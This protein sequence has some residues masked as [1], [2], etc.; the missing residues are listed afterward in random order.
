MKKIS[1]LFILFIFA[2]SSRGMA[3][4][5]SAESLENADYK[6]DL[7]NAL[8]EGDCSFMGVDGFVGNYAIN[9]EED[10][11]YWVYQY[12][13]KHISGTGDA[14]RNQEEVR[15]NS[16]GYEYASKYNKALIKALK[17]D[18]KCKSPSW[19]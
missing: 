6:A 18:A 15:I 11:G 7:A 16:I 8:K 9:A 4:E 10:Y 13:K 12:G 14:L 1:I 5:I 17:N 3:S 19:F 2:C